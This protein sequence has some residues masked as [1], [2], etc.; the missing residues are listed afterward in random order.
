VLGPIALL[1]ALSAPAVAHA[2]ATITVTGTA[3]H[4]TLTYPVDDA[5]DH[6]ASAA[7]LNGGLEI[8]DSIGRPSGCAPSGGGQV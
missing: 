7:I 2:D 8:W 5:L 4:K 3:P 1:L 6:R